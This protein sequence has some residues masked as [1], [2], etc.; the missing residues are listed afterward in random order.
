VTDP[1]SGLFVKGSYNR[2]FA[3]EA[4]PPADANGSVPEAV[5]TL[6]NVHDG[7]I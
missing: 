7:S 6:G 5:V 2:Q 4:T 1:D 3:Y